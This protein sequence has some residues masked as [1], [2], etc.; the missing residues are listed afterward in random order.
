MA[1]AE[2]VI[3]DAARHATVYAQA[4]WHRH[5]PAKAGPEPVRLADVAQRLDLLIAAVFGRGFALRMAQPPAPPTFLSRFLRRHEPPPVRQALPATDGASLWLPGAFG[6]GEPAAR[7]F[8]RFRTVALQQA[9][10]AAR[11]SAEALPADGDPLLRDLYLLLEA[12]AADHALL[13]RLPGMAGA[14]AALR[15]EALHQRPPLTAFA[16]PLRPLERLARAVLA[17]PADASAVAALQASS[18]AA[19][20]ALSDIERALLAPDMA[21]SAA[22]PTDV[23]ASALAQPHRAT[24]STLPG[25]R[26]AVPAPATQDSAALLLALPATPAQVLAQAQT[27]LGALQAA[28]A[29]GPAD[30]WLWRDLWTGE[31]RRPGATARSAMAPAAQGDEEDDA[32][33]PPRSARLA[34]RPEVREGDD[35]ED[36]AR[37][38]A[39]M[40]QTAQPHEQ[41]EDPMGLQRPTDR[42]SETAAEEF[43]DALSELPEA[44]LVATPGKPKEVLLS[45]DPPEARA[46]RQAWAAGSGGAPDWLPYPEWDWRAGAYRDPGATVLLQPAAPGPQRWIDETLAARR[47]ML[48]EIRRRFELLRAQRVRLHRQLDGGEIDLPAYIEA[49]ADFRAGLPLA[50]RVY[51]GERRGRRD[52]AVMLLVDVSGSTDGWIAG[53]RRVIDVEREALLLVCVALQGLAAPFSVQAFSG[54]GPHAVVVRSVKRFDEPCDNAVARRIAGLEPEHYTRA[55]AALRHASALLM[56]ER[57]EHRLLLLLSDGKPNDIDD[58]EG[59]YGVEDLRQ[60][61]TEA[62]LQGIS[63][64]CLTIDRQAAS[65]LPA[66]FGP[67]QYALLPRPELLPTVLLDWLRRLVAA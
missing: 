3:T 21:A 58:Y 34:R 52:L 42:D 54:E 53:D 35:D 5:R 44:R 31:L 36:D 64:F 43:A 40:V 60:A 26:D 9:V 20:L 16:T 23:N 65:Y 2:D 62:R 33:T 37:P 49:R 8:E 59:R 6:P 12:R 51:R 10:R 55:G 27:L 57:A 38:G 19:P 50:Q 18:A 11:G 1:E 29:A 14:L 67:G 47:G 4:L 46:R 48:D 61:V 32:A 39:W 25:T 30:R 56:R 45:D 13:Q 24:A 22:V 66:V 7:S 63:P 17:A 41:A 15:R 28:G